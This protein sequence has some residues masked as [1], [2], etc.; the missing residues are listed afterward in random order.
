MGFGNKKTRI[1]RVV[2]GPGT[3]VVGVIKLERKMELFISESAKVG[4]VGGEMLI[5]D[6]VRFS[7]KKP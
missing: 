1:S 4:G 3:D 5:N 6:A 7:G 2:I